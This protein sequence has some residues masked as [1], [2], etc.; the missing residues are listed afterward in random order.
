MAHKV[1]ITIENN[2][3][4]R[5]TYLEHKFEDGCFESKNSWPKFIEPKS[6]IKTL[7]TSKFISVVG[8]SGWAKYDF[9]GTPIFFCFSNPMIGSNGIDVGDSSS[10]FKNMGSHYPDGIEAQ[11]YIKLMTEGKWLSVDISNT[12]GLTTNALWTLESIDVQKVEESNIEMRDVYGAYKSLTSEATR[13]Y[14]KCDNAPTAITGLV[15][16]HFK[17]LAFYKNKIIFTHTNMGLIT[18]D[19]GKYL[20]ASNLKR[21]TQGRIEATYETEHKDWSHPCSSQACGSFMAMGIE[22]SASG[23]LESEINI[24]DIR[25]VQVNQPA[26]FVTKIQRKEGVNGVAITKETSG[27]GGKYIVAAGEGKKISIYKSTHSSLFDP[28]LKF[29][30]M[31]NFDICDDK[32]EFN[33]SGSGLALIT[34]KD[35]SIFLITLNDN[36][37]GGKSKMNLYKLNGSVLSL[38]EDS[39][40]FQ[41]V[42]SK[43]MPIGDVSESIR[44][45]QYRLAAIIVALPVVGAALSALLATLG[46]KYLN[47]SLR[48][49][50]GLRIISENKFEVYATDRNVLPLSKIPLVGSDKDFSLVTWNK[51]KN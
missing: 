4:S 21:N 40:Y 51:H 17:G 22:K 43:D 16:S 35:G 49:G 1:A 9:D 8:C 30:L 7:C 15:K 29:E 3:S 44:M 12:S 18:N 33:A 41:R 10:A 23:N 34:Q 46:V 25:N 45:L 14:Y 27:N 31:H 2:T 26:K 42:D 50:K 48:W 47:S 37:G 5:L 19:P 36:D 6:A 20:V 28:N 38:G 13:K 39:P 32:D 24:Y 11:K